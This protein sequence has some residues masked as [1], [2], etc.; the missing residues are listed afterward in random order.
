MWGPSLGYGHCVD[1]SRQSWLWL[2]VAA[3]LVCILKSYVIWGFN[4]RPMI[5]WYPLPRGS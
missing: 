2:S 4:L 3:C 1:L 5:L